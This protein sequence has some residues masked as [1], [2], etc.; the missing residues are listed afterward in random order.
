MGT[1]VRALLSGPT[2]GPYLAPYGRLM[3][4]TPGIEIRRAWRQ[5]GET[6]RIHYIV[7][8]PDGTERRLYAADDSGLG[9]LL[10]SALTAQG[11]TGPRSAE[12]H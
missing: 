12:E 11:Y 1:C 6:G 3:P 7:T 5:K 9:K 2:H 10:D 8:T 4:H